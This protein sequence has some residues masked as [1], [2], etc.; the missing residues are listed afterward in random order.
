MVYCITRLYYCYTYSIYLY[1]SSNDTFP[2]VCPY[3]AG[4]HILIILLLLLL[5]PSFH[6]PISYFSGQPLWPKHCV[7]QSPAQLLIAKPHTFCSLY[8]YSYSN[9]QTTDLHIFL[10]LNFWINHQHICKAFWTMTNNLSVTGSAYCYWWCCI[11]GKQGNNN[12]FHN[13][14]NIY[15]EIMVPTNFY[16]IKWVC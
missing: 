7:L 9:I 15:W 12:K 3:L 14:I 2:P 16:W 11:V 8:S 13:I 5:S 4:P 1:L 10:F 6:L